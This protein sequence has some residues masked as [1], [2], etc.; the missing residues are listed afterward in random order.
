MLDQ[1]SAR[2]RVGTVLDDKYRLEKLLGLGGMGAVYR[3]VHQWTERPVAV[4]LL[5]DDVSKNE[6]SVERFFREARALSRVGH[7]GIVQVLDLGRTS[8]DTLYLVQELLDGE[9]LRAHMNRAGKLS[10]TEC[11]R[12]V[13]PVLDALDAAHAAGMI[14]RDVKPENIVLHKE[15]RGGVEPKLIDFGVARLDVQGMRLTRAGSLLGTPHYMAPEQVRGELDTDARADLW[16]LGVVLFEC[17]SGQRP[18]SADNIRELFAKVTLEPVPSL[19][20]V[21]PSLPEAFVRVVDRA[22]AK[23]PAR[24]WP[25]ARAMLIEFACVPEV[26]KDPTLAATFGALGLDAPSNKTAI[27]GSAFVA[28]ALAAE[29]QPPQPVAPSV[30]K[31]SEVVPAPSP[32]PS[33]S[34]PPSPS[35]SSASRP[36]GSSPTVPSRPALVSPRPTPPESAKPDPKLGRI[37]LAVSL[38]SAVLVVASYTLRPTREAALPP[39]PPAQNTQPAAT[40][41]SG[42]V[43]VAVADASAAR[44]VHTPDVALEPAHTIN[45]APAVPDAGRPGPRRQ[46]PTNP[47][48]RNGFID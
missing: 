46:R 32:S 25:S 18:Y 10:I 26:R 33:P 23:E 5:F 11:A 8:D 42:V 41:D 48:L 9:T 34:P 35:P 13:L 20:V 22:L 3:G 7:K 4:K 40:A 37:A 28:A 29:A 44:V 38:T 15:P 47:S 21:E 36:R 6:E 16:S 14:H 45:V 2:D 19:G 17:A 12:I 1:Q 43:V 24:R 39:T 30:T 31:T 27:A